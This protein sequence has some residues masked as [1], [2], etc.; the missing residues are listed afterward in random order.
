MLYIRRKQMFLSL[1]VIFPVYFYFVACIAPYIKGSLP[2]TVKNMTDN[3]IKYF[4]TDFSYHTGRVLIISSIIY[5]MMT[6]I[7]ISCMRNTRNGAEYGSAKF[8]SVFMLARRYKDRVKEANIR[9]TQNVRIALNYLIHKKN[10]NILI[11]GGSGTGKSRG[12]IIPNL[13]TANSSFIVTDPKGY[14]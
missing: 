4:P 5:F 13:L 14:I 11:I 8:G 7:I 3:E 6:F 1:L 12:F 9:L 10:L 2:E